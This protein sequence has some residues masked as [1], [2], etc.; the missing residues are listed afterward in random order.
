MSSNAFKQISICASLQLTVKL[1]L[2]KSVLIEFNLRKLSILDIY[3]GSINVKL[4]LM[5][6]SLMDKFIP[7][8][9]NNIVLIPILCFRSHIKFHNFL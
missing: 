1:I 8:V 7:H 3:A 4:D 5:L 9:L 6:D 2:T